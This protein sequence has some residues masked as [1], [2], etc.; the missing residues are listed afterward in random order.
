SGDDYCYNA[1]LARDGVWKMQWTSY[2]EVSMYNGN[3]YA[4]NLLSGFFGLNPVWGAPILIFTSVA[5]WLLGATGVTLEVSR[6]IGWNIKKIEAFLFS[7]VI[8]NFILVS[9]PD[10]QQSLFWRSG[11]LPYFLPLV[12]IVLMGWLGLILH[13]RSVKSWFGLS[14]EFMLALLFSGFSESGTALLIG[15]WGVGFLVSLYGYFKDQSKG[16]YWLGLTG[17]GLLGSLIGLAL[18]YFSP[19]TALRRLNMPDPIGIMALIKLLLSNL[20]VFFWQ[21]LM[22]KTLYLVLPVAFG[23]GLGFL[24]PKLPLF[25]SKKRAWLRFIGAGVVIGVLAVFLVALIYLPATYIFADYP[26]PRAL[27]LAQFVMVAA[28][29]SGGI[30]LSVLLRKLAFKIIRGDNSRKVVFGVLSLLL[31]GSSIFAPFT[32]VKGTLSEAP[33]VLRWSRLWVNRHEDL[34][35]AGLENAEEVHVI[36]LD[37]VINDVGELSPDSEYWYNNC[38]EMY[39]GIDAIFA[40]QP[41]W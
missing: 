19:S 24:L 2:T 37:H 25:E 18:L 26:P 30:W 14:L 10:L 41:G 8:L 23:L 20:K 3:R 32:L 31:I 22:R 6:Q 27:I 16:R 39:Y 38:A 11:M 34:V 40:D 21:A 15:L 13:R 29:V 33:K 1:I 5:L 9:T 36:Q 7:L 12:G 17:I 35:Q 4:L 28:E